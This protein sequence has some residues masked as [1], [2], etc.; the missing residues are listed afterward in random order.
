[1]KR[2]YFIWICGYCDKGMNGERRSDGKPSVHGMGRSLVESLKDRPLRPEVCAD[3]FKTR[4]L[5]QIEGQGI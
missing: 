3:C 5:P 1:M 4:V 2:P